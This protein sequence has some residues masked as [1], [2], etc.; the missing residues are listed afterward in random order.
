M[1][2]GFLFSSP[3]PGFIV[4]RFFNWGSTFLKSSW[5]MLRLLFQGPHYGSKTA[6][7]P[8]YHK[9]WN[10]RPLSLPLG[11]WKD[12]CKFGWQLSKW[13]SW[14]S[15]VPVGLSGGSVVKNLPTNAGDMGSIPCLGRS[16]GEGYGSPFQYSCLENPWKEG[17][18]QATVH[19]VAKQ[20]NIT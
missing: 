1:Q 12:L 11:L 2:E 20:L 17:A 3:S 16:P 14:E 7:C 6:G 18:W 9:Y 5:V 4:C 15:N 8:V 19:G 10:T 13:A